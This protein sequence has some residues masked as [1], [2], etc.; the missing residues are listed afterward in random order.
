MLCIL[1]LS[2]LILFQEFTCLA[3]NYFL[4]ETKCDE[5]NN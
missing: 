1:N 5:Q 2:K 4:K 3:R